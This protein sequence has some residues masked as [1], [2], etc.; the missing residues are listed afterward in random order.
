MSSHPSF[1]RSVLVA[2][3]LAGSGTQLSAADTDAFLGRW[4][5]AL[6]GGGAGW[7]GVTRE[8]GYYDGSILWGGGSVVPVSSI[9]FV[10]ERNQMTSLK[11]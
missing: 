9:V 1:F 2:S 10:D 11:E 8:R 3:L 7:L 4:A 5:L 6:P